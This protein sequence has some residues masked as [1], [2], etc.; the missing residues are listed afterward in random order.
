[1]RTA[2]PGQRLADDVTVAQH[3]GPVADRAHL[4]GRVGDQQDGAA[5]VLEDLHPVDALALEAL[6]ADRQHLVDTRMSGSTLTATAKPRRTY[7][8][9]E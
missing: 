8:P 1:M 9:E 7:M 3:D 4:V 5:L 2:S 6:V